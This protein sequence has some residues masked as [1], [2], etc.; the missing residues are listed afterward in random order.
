[1][2]FIDGD[3][4]NSNSNNNSL[5]SISLSSQELKLQK[6]QHESCENRL[7]RCLKFNKNVHK[8]I[9]DIHLLGCEV[10][11]NLFTCIRCENTGI[12][13]GFMPYLPEDK[14]HIP[15]ISI[16]EDNSLHFKN[17]FESTIIHEL[18]SLYY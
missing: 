6:Q 18:V 15:N 1:M 2:S 10:P 17:A 4:S 12:S 13:G 3:A 11:K 16:C 7:S 5:S 14:T 9:Q 8:L